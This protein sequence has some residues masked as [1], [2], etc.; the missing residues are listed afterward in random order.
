MT[1]AIEHNVEW[2]ASLLETMRAEGH[3][4]VEPDQ[5]AQ[6]AWTEE[7]LQAAQRLLATSVDSWFTGVN[8]N[9]DR[10][11]GRR[12]L[13]YTGG[14]PRFRDLCAEEAAAGYPSFRRT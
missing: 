11:V 9:V 8:A 2:I 12:V 7:V 4:R 5:G 6:D 3:D 14:F 13:I 1:R 10:G